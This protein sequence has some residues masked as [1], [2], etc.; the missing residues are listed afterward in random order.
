VV[1]SGELQD[2][3]LLYYNGSTGHGRWE[4]GLISDIISDI[5]TGRDRISI[6]TA[7]NTIDN[8]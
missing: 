1:I 8:P 7:L 2:G 5:P 6:V 3:M 4:A